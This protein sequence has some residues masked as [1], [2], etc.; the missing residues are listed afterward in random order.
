MRTKGLT[1]L[2]AAVALAGMTIACSEAPKTPAANGNTAAPLPP[3]GTEKVEPKIV[4]DE[5]GPDNSY[6][7]VRQL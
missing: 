2:C 1:L 7:T 3:G 5:A 4:R 6:I